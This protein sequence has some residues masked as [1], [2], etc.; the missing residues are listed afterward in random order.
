MRRF[1]IYLIIVAACMTIGFQTY[2]AYEYSSLELERNDMTC[3]SLLLKSGTLTAKILCEREDRA[4]CRYYYTIEDK[5]LYL[6]FYVTAGEK[7]V[8][9]TDENGYYNLEIKNVG[10]IEKVCYRDYKK[11][12]TLTLHYE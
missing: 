5:V 2:I 10:N 1:I 7:R 12:H 9:E 4:L 6:T 11:D 8:L 3:E